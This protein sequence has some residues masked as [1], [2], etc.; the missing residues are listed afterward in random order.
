MLSSQRPIITAMTATEFRKI[1]EQHI[2]N[3]LISNPITSMMP[4]KIQ[5][6]LL[7]GIS[8]AVGPTKNCTEVSPPAKPDMANSAAT[9]VRR[10]TTVSI[11]PA[12]MPA[13][14][15]AVTRRL[16][17]FFDAKISESV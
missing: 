9:Q 15:F 11:I 8:I 2:A 4:A 13:K 10:M 17:P 16:L 3:M 12:V 6:A 7:T 5:N 14:S 1:C